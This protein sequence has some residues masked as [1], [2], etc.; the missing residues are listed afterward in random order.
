MMWTEFVRDAFH[1]TASSELVRIVFDFRATVWKDEVVTSAQMTIEVVSNLSPGGTRLLI[2]FC[3][4]DG[5]FRNFCFVGTR[6]RLLQDGPFVAITFD[7]QLQ[8]ITFGRGI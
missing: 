6:L 3:F 7:N 1:F 2:I 5:F 8:F 4:I